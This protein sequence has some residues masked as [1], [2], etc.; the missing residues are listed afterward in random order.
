[1]VRGGKQDQAGK[2]ET[3]PPVP[4]SGMRFALSWNGREI[5]TEERRTTHA[6]TRWNRTMGSGST[7]GGRPRMV[8]RA[9]GSGACRGWLRSWLA[10]PGLSLRMG[11][12]GRRQGRVGLACRGTL[13]PRR[14]ASTAEG[15][16]GPLGAGFG[17]GAEVHGRPGAGARSVERDNPVAEQFEAPEGV[18][19]SPFPVMG[20]G[21]LF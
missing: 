10:R 8:G 5:P 19:R 6:G 4:S 14:G 18:T 17:A 2:I 20:K 7:N 11:S 21:F 13:E 16:Y 3:G 9:C 15:L 1:M 12:L